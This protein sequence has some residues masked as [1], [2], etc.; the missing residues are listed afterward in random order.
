MQTMDIYNLLEDCSAMR[1][2]RVPPMCSVCVH[3][4]MC[5]CTCGCVP[6]LSQ[7]CHSEGV[8]L[9]AVAG[10]MKDDQTLRD[11]KVSEGCKMMVVGS[12]LTDVMAVMPPP[13]TAEKES[14][15]VEGEWK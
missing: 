8:V 3:V 12:T 11:H 7:L 13:S 4:H 10:L 1:D 2:V 9:L 5:V 6:M 14:R 15:H